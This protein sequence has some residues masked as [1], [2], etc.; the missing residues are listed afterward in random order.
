MEEKEGGRSEEKKI[1]EGKQGE[2][3]IESQVGKKDEQRQK[4]CEMKREMEQKVG[5]DKTMN[6][7]GE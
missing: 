1:N 6:N 2:G 5:Y 3:G 7:K 4:E